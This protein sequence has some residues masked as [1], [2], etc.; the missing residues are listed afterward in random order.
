M[1]VGRQQPPKE[2]P[3]HQPNLYLAAQHPP[4]FTQIVSRKASKR[5]GNDSSLLS[6]TP[7]FSRRWERLSNRSFTLNLL[8]S[9]QANVRAVQNLALHSTMGSFS[10]QTKKCLSLLNTNLQLQNSSKEKKKNYFKVYRIP[11]PLLLRGLY[12]TD[13]YFKNSSIG[14]LAHSPETA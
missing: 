4:G 5:Y 13:S 12:K 10:I 9:T 8:L 3:N 6:Q 14:E 11:L 2:N 7:L 1:W